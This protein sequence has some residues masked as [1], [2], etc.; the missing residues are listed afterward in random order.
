MCPHFRSNTEEKIPSD[1]SSLFSKWSSVVILVSLLLCPCSQGYQLKHT[2]FLCNL[3]LLPTA[4]IHL[5]SAKDTFCDFSVP[6]GDGTF[7][8]F[9]IITVNQNVLGKHQ[10]KK[11]LF[12]PPRIKPFEYIP[13][14][15]V[16]S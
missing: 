3:P 10:M 16:L 5:T 9:N 6:T 15:M 11:Q 2:S 12:L 13:L 1:W 7:I 8:L 14:D 4:K